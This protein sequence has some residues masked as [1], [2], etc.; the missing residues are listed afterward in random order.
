MRLGLLKVSLNF[1]HDIIKGLS[2]GDI[3]LESRN[4]IPIL[5]SVMIQGTHLSPFYVV[6][7]DFLGVLPLENCFT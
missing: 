3:E 2:L 6:S 5:P 1:H 7:S 4:I